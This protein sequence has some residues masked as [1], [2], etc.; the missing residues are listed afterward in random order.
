M[1]IAL[2]I[3]GLII[4]ILLWLFS[5][6]PLRKFLNKLTRRNAGFQKS[7]LVQFLVRV[8]A[9]ERRYWNEVESPPRAEFISSFQQPYTQVFQLTDFVEDVDPGFDITLINELDSAFVVHDLG[10]EIVSVAN[11]WKLYG[12]PQAAKISQQA[13][14]TIKIPDIRTEIS[15]SEDLRL[16]EP[17][18]IDMVLSA[19]MPDPFRLEPE[20]TFRY[21]LLLKNYVAHMP[22]YAL[23]RFWIT[24]QKGKFASELVQ[25]FTI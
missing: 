17:R 10:I 19:H 1:E 9:Q 25:T 24:T 22:N 15:R 6:E 8:A 3:I 11:E 18:N 4:A 13:S 2:S 14:Y 20:S 5:P 12:S 23:I 7:N 16:L 21:E